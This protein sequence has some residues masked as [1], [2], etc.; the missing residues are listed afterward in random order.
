MILSPKHLPR[1]A[2]TVG[3]SPTTA[4]ATSPSGR[5]CSASKAP[6]AGGGRARRT[7]MLTTKAKAF[8]ERLVE[9]GPAYIK[10]GQVL[11]TRPDLLPQP[12]IDELE[13]LQDD[14]P[15]MPFETSSR[16]SRRSCTPASASSSPRSTQEPLGSAS[17]GQVHAARAARRTRASSSRC[18][19]RTSASSSPKTSSSSASSRPFSPSTPRPAREIDMVGVVQQVE[20]ALVDELDYR[21][22]ARNA[23][24]FRRALAEFPHILIPRVID[25]YTTHSVLTTERIRGV[26]I[27]AIPPISRDRVRL[28][29]ARRRICARVPRS[30]SRT[31][32]ISTPTRIRATFSSSCPVRDNPRTPAEAV[33]RRPAAG[34]PEAERTALGGVGERSTRRVGRLARGRPTT[35][36]WR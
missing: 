12:Y 30:R 20:R 5:D 32:V 8:R 4:C 23:A 24:A 13:H 31:P 21:T 27:D 11:S 28:H 9:L 29:R 36:S 25:A 16:R 19:A 14:V 34:S 7:V 15:P 2:A 26:K 1:L 35:R 10:L 6:A 33:A 22:E 18:S 17:L 3:F